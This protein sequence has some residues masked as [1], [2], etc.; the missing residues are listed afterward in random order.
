MLAEWWL[1]SHKIK[2]NKI[3][4]NFYKNTK[5]NYVG[6]FFIVICIKML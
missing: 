3:N 2:N 6:L 1:G 4:R 5:Y